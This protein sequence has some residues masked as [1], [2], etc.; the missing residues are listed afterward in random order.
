MA[1]KLPQLGPKTLR[2]TRA[3]EADFDSIV[4]YIADEAGDATAQRFATALDAE[5]TKLALLGHS[6]VSREA[7]SSG[8]RLTVFGN[9]CIYFRLTDDD[10]IIVRILHGARD[11]RQISFEGD[12]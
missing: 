7:V 2:L 8:L 11:I 10:T 3:S 5:L 6:G 1:N 4:D 12:E 9:Y